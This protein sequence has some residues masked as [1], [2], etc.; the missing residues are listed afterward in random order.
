MAGAHPR[1]SPWGQWHRVRD[2]L[3]REGESGSGRS[4]AL[5]AQLL[6]PWPPCFLFFS[7]SSQ[8]KSPSCFPSKHTHWPPEWPSRLQFLRA[9]STPWA[10]LL[11][12]FPSSLRSSLAIIFTSSTSAQCLQL[13]KSFLRGQVQI[14]CA[15]MVDYNW[16]RF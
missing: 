5:Y 14:L 2:P 13:T 8:Q 1:W 10:P 16:Q 15:G 11:F 4:L 6:S 9:P 12:L 3:L 7:I